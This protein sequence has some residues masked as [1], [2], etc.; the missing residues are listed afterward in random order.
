MPRLSLAGDGTASEPEAPSS[1][2]ASP[3]SGPHGALPRLVSGCCTG[4][5]TCDGVESPAGGAAY[6]A[7]SASSV[8]KGRR[9]VAAAFWMR[10]HEAVIP[11]TA[12]SP[13]PAHV[14]TYPKL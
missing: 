9:I 10:W 6:A 3:R 7:T 2:T 12:F 13:S 11:A 4:D 8:S 1:D 14:A 5:S